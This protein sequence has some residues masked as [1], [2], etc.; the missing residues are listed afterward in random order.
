[1]TPTTRPVSHL[2]DLA[3][4]NILK[5]QTKSIRKRD[6]QNLE[7]ELL[8]QFFQ[9]FDIIQNFGRDGP[10]IIFKFFDDVVLRISLRKSYSKLMH[11]TFEVGITPALRA[12]PS[13]F[14]AEFDGKSSDISK[15]NGNN[16]T[17]T[18]SHL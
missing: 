4:V 18:D 17:R 11:S 3:A 13:G 6:F 12:M 15:S 2:A 8:V 5:T 14:L 1:M 16:L 7:I 9:D 10:D